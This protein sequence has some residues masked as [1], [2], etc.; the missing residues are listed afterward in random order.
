ARTTRI[1]DAASANAR[2]Y[3]LRG[4]TRLVAHTVLRFGGTMAP[5]ASLKRFSWLYD[6]DAT[7]QIAK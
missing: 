1:V 3:H 4:I 6:Y 2:N 7:Q 5:N